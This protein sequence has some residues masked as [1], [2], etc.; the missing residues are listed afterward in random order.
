MV[1]F[2]FPQFSTTPEKSLKT[3]K[4]SANT[5]KSKKTQKRQER[6]RAFALQ[7][8]L[9]SRRQQSEAKLMR[10]KQAKEIW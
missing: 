6:A 8:R 5:G 7:D 3:V 9:E 2:T 4:S 1:E 10:R